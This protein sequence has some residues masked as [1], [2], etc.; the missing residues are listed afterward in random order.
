ML[1]RVNVEHELDK[2]PLQARAIAEQEGE[3][4]SRHQGRPLE[5]HDAERLAQVVVG[6]RREVEIR[7]VPP[8]PRDHVVLLGL[9]DRHRFVEEIWDLQEQEVE[10]M[11]HRVRQLERGLRLIGHLAKPDLQTVVS[12][13]G[14]FLREPV[15]FGLDRLRLVQVGAPGLVELQDLID[16]RRFTFELGRPPHSLGVAADQLQRKH[17]VSA[18][19]TGNRIT[20]LTD[21]WS[22][23][24]ITRPSMP[25]PHPP[26]T[27]H[28][29]TTPP[30]T[31][32]TIHY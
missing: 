14:E 32:S 22:V 2:R 21:G 10:L 11:F 24:S 31:T 30:T 23:S 20:S 18:F 9:T 7:L 26:P 1:A 19:M 17:Y 6:P 8:L 5:V 28:P 27:R 12:R 4:R 16:R 29:Y 3:T 15:L 25:T 13:P